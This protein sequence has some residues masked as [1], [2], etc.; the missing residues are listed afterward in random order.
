MNIIF[1]NNASINEKVYTLCML[2]LLACSIYGLKS[3]FYLKDSIN[4]NVW[5][6]FSTAFLISI[7]FFFDKHP[8]NKI[9]RLPLIKRTFMYLGIICLSALF[10]FSFIYMFLPSMYTKIWGEP[11][12]GQTKIISKTNR[13]NK[14][15]CDIRIRVELLNGKICISEQFYNTVEVGDELI[16]NG[17]ESVYG[18]K[19]F[20]LSPTSN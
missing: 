15:G 10:T 18:Y 1:R 13:F 2:A 4:F 12:T 16:L 8:K 5:I 14:R 3:D 6:I 20:T 9:N 19:V 11:F 7:P 17:I